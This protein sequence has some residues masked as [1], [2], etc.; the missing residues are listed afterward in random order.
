MPLEPYLRGSTWW[1]K[2][3]VE[4]NGLQ[5]TSYYRQSTGASSRTGAEDW[6]AAETER[7]IR[8]HLLGEDA[9]LTFNDAVLLYPAKP[10]DAKFLTKIIPILGERLCNSISGSEVRDLGPGLYPNCSTDTWRR[11]VISPVSAVI[12]YAHD[13]RLCAPIRIKG[14][15]PQERID[16]DA[17]RGKLSRQKRPAGSWEWIDSV[18]PHCNVYVAAGLEMMFETG[19]RIGQL[20]AIEPDDLD[21]FN[22]KVRIIAQKGHEEQ[23]ITISQEMMVTLANLPP[24]RPTNLITGAKGDPKV[25]GY[26]NRTGFTS[27]L[28]TA[29]RNAGVEY[30]SPHEAGRRGFY[31]ELRVRQGADPVTSAKAGRWKNH[32]VPDAIYASV[33]AGEDQIRSRIRTNRVQKPRTKK[34]K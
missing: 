13:K 17:K 23:W 14:Y 18:T 32:K 21:L 30:M 9:S 10:A 5:I 2:G 12:N 16:Q 22:R 34:A 6:V 11:Q 27:A 15:T 7:Q 31:T 1:V 3:R 33:E 8:C 26:D 25:F 4:Y 24:R 20:I 19:I 29:C 28:R